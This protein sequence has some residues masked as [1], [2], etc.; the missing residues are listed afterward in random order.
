MSNVGAEP[1]CGCLVDGLTGGGS[2]QPGGGALPTKLGVCRGA[3]LGVTEGGGWEGCMV[4]LEDTPD[5]PKMFVYCGVEEF[6]TVYV[7]F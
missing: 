4:A 3:T 2:F 6:A 5:D 7:E 1:P